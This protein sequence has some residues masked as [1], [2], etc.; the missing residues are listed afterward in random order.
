MQS[1]DDIQMGGTRNKLDD[2]ICVQ[3]NFYRLEMDREQPDRVHHGQGKVLYK[4]RNGER[5]LAGGKFMRQRRSFSLM[6][7]V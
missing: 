1:A 5:S 4:E 2:G 7:S 6:C 3:I